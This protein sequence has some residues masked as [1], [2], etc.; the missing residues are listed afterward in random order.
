MAT[1]FF[2]IYIDRKKDI[3]YEDVKEKMD[4]SLD[5]YR[6]SDKQWI[7]Y[8]SS[9]PETLYERLGPLV[10]ETGNL[11]IC[12]LEESNRQGWMPKDFWEWLRKA[13]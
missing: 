8:S 1:H 4:R 10:K 9:D 11:F 13:R 3:T 5:W 7:V 6:I 2:M 12:Q